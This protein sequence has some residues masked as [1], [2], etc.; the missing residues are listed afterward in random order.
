M[1]NFAF[2]LINLVHL[3]YLLLWD[4]PN[5]HVEQNCFFLQ[6]KKKEKK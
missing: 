4:K 2:F 3:I 5:I 6:K 1:C